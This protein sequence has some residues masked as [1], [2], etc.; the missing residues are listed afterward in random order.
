MGTAQ[1][2]SLS[3]GGGGH[4]QGE[5]T[6]AAAIFNQGKIDGGGRVGTVSGEK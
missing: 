5:A 3:P 2:S 6:F 4:A 1:V